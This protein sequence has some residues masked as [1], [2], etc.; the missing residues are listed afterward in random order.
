MRRPRTSKAPGDLTRGR[1]EQ[2]ARQYLVLVHVKSRAP[3]IGVRV[4]IEVVGCYIER[5]RDLQRLRPRSILSRRSTLIFVS[6]R[7]SVTAMPRNSREP[8]QAPPGPASSS[9]STE[10]AP[11]LLRRPATW[12]SRPNAELIRTSTLDEAAGMVHHLR[13]PT[14]SRTAAARRGRLDGNRIKRPLRCRPGSCERH[15]GR[16]HR[17]RRR[18]GRY[19]ARR[20]RVL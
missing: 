3:P 14:G 20:D 2:A 12:R 16:M 6:R 19:P 10:S 15:F 1:T 18:P 11:I 9:R 17:V 4:R 5:P 13:P 7:T 8:T